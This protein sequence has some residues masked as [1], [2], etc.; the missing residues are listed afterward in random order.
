[1]KHYIKES[2]HSPGKAAFKMKTNRGG[3]M[4]LWLKVVEKSFV[5][6]TYSW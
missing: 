3:E 4:A 6:R 5:S 1:M 2:D